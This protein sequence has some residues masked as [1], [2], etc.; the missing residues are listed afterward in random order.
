ML[1]VTLSFHTIV[2]TCSQ[3][4]DSCLRVATQRVV[5]MST[6]VLAL[7][8]NTFL[9]AFQQCESPQDM[10]VHLLTHTSMERYLLET[11]PFGFNR[12]IYAQAASDVA[13]V[14]FNLDRLS[15][16]L[17]HNI[18]S[19]RFI[20][21]TILDLHKD[22]CYKP[23]DAQT[24]GQ[25]Q[26]AA[27]HAQLPAAFAVPL[28]TQQL[29]LL[30]THCSHAQLEELQQASSS[31]ATVCELAAA[32][33][34]DSQAAQELLPTRLISDAVAMLS[35][36]GQDQ[37]APA[38]HQGP[39][40]GFFNQ[41]DLQLAHLQPVRDF[42]V[43]QYRQQG[44][45][46]ADVSPLLKAPLQAGATSALKLRLAQGCSHSPDNRQALAD[47]VAAL[48]AV[49]LEALPSQA[50]KGASLQSVCKFLEYEAAEF[51]VSALGPDV[52]CSQYAAVMRVMLQV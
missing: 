49:E 50:N 42:M 20:T 25:P 8:Q 3:P 10:P 23:T 41:H 5:R 9:E 16:Q 11:N 36:Q 24:H 35:E 6:A 29:T 39:G 40:P 18:A 45:Q 43:E 22:F 38:L 19:K 44:Y 15:Q 17:K 34:G 4:Y 7:L 12:Y 21:N 32:Q 37:Q 47:L 33:Q 31:L 2:E 30:E 27:N 52:A 46:F 48:R 51:P 1:L 14:E 13:P 28:S 26:E